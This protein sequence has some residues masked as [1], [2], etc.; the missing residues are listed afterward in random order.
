[1]FRST[2]IY[3]PYFLIASRVGKEAEV[4]EWIRKKYDGQVMKVEG[5]I[6]EDLKLVRSQ[7]PPTTHSAQLAHIHAFILARYAVAKPLSRP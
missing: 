6:K 2:L 7:N 3:H 5:V 1:M 4:E